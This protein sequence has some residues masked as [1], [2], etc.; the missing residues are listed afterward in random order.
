MRERTAEVGKMRPST[1]IEQ[2]RWWALQDL[3]L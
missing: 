2:P 1:H 3:N